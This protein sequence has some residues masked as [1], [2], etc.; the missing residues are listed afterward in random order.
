MAGVCLPELR[1]NQGLHPELQRRQALRRIA[2]V[3]HRSRKN[4]A[5]R[6]CSSPNRS[7]QHPLYAACPDPYPSHRTKPAGAALQ[8]RSIWPEL[9]V[10]RPNDTSFE[11]S[12]V[13]RVPFWTRTPDRP[14]IGVISSNKYSRLRVAEGYWVA[15]YGTIICR[16]QMMSAQ[17]W[18][19]RVPYAATRCPPKFQFHSART[20][21]WQYF[22][23][24]YS[25]AL[26]EV[27]HIQ[28]PIHHSDFHT[29]G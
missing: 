23:L 19:E 6:D 27:C 28:A 9:A 16:E 3:D 12:C 17:G 22:R 18:L 14:R 7:C 2:S 11:F 21:K 5:V 10:S 24:I 20:N 8:S 29:S 26:N 13:W 15:A 1:G 4:P 25:T